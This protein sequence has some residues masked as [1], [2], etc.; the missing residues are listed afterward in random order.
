MSEEPRD[1]PPDQTWMTTEQIGVGYGLVAWCG[2]AVA[3]AIALVVTLALVA[4]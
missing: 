1:P 3:V 4:S 2:L